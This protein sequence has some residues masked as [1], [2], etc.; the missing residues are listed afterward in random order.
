[1]S[2][3]SSA[4]DPRVTE[5][6]LGL[7]SQPRSLNPKWFYDAW[8][9]HLFE[10]I[11]RQPEYYLTGC[12]LNILR[13]HAQAIG[14]WVGPGVA[15]A[16]LGA[17]NGEKAMRLISFLNPR[18]YVPI[19]ISVQSLQRAVDSIRQFQP[20]IEVNPLCL[21]FMEGIRW[22]D[23]LSLGPR[24][25]AFLGSTMGNLDPGDAVRWLSGLR[26]HL[27]RTDKMLIG[28][29]LKK[30]ENIMN[31]A[32]NDAQ[33]VTAAFN[34][35]ALAHVNRA[36]G[37]NFN[38][39]S[40]RHEAFYNPACSRVQMQLVAMSDEVIRIGGQTLSV[41][42]HECIHTENSYKY[43]VK[44]FHTL[45]E[46]AGFQVDAVWVDSRQWFGLFGL[47]VTGDSRDG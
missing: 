22:P 14:K 8:G 15:L 47:V 28:V 11:T 23:G 35:N 31:A 25:L 1:M 6:L 37:A 16:E 27:N 40:F 3:L 7:N 43:D 26:Q 17:G 46:A 39:A 34:L 18:C 13:V 36:L 45:T 29:D 19:D 21:D 42:A 33:H 32:Y 38:L 30:D 4:G 5:V 10:E 44:D 2:S 41:L 9:S 24:C 20:G 12:E